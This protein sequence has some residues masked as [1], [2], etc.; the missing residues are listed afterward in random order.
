M[1]ARVT[2]SRLF[3]VSTLTPRWVG[4]KGGLT[5][6]LCP[7]VSLF[8]RVQG[9]LEVPLELPNIAR[10]QGAQQG[11]YEQ[12]VPRT[13]SGHALSRNR[14]RRYLR[15]E[16]GVNVEGLATGDATF[17]G[18]AKIKVGHPRTPCARPSAD[19]L[20]EVNGHM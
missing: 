15:F 12:R 5:L 7:G 19:H 14:K 3:R 17:P 18:P 10:N 1:H 9:R 13:V 11:T 8:A 6:F 4:A 2:S 16:I 20:P